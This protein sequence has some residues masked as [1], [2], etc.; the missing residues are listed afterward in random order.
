[1]KLAYLAATECGRV[2]VS[3]QEGED[4]NHCE[5]LAIS[6]VRT[7]IDSQIFDLCTYPAEAFH[8]VG[9]YELCTSDLDASPERIDA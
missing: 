3:V 7:L 1:M 8:A 2:F 5:G 4:A 6:A 9:T